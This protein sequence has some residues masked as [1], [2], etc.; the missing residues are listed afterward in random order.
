MG[1]VQ[2]GIKCSV[3]DCKNKAIR[4]LSREKFSSPDLQVK[5]EGKKVYLC[6]IHYKVWKKNLR[7]QKSLYGTSPFK[8]PRWGP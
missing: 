8:D 7:K 6:E 1:K 2:K 4:S 3:I 5:T